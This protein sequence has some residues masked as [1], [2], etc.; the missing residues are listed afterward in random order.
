[1]SEKNKPTPNTSSKSVKEAPVNKNVSS[2]SGDS[3]LELQELLRKYLPE[4]AENT[5]EPE[6]FVN[7]PEFKDEQ[8]M[9]ELIPEQL[10]VAE[11]ALPQIP[12]EEI[13]MM[14]EDPLP[15]EKKKKKGLFSRLFSSG[16]AKADEETEAP[17]GA[18][19]DQ[20]S[21]EAEE[22]SEEESAAP[23]EFS[24]EE[25]IRIADDLQEVQP[26]V[27][28]ES[29]E[30]P[31]TEEAVVTEAA[32]IAEEKIEHIRQN[33]SDVSEEELNNLMIAL[34]LES[35]DEMAEESA[36]SE[37]TEAVEEEAQE[38]DET[39]QNLLVGLGMEDQLDER[40][41]KGTAAR[42]VAKND[43]DARAYEQQHLLR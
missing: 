34:G 43:A 23:A 26:L 2:S 6:V 29:A 10:S 17:D 9:P 22:P 13:L 37:Q 14:E 19:F 11:E 24:S 12:T 27:N 41:G 25:D 35:S 1:M 8:P 15:T 7:V 40:A 3:E 38:L 4:F 21:A 39:V 30:M 33:G 42:T 20:I 32:E 18:L 5:E 36:V 16:K 28:E 31:E